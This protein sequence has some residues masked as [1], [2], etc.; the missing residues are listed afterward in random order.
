MRSLML[1]LLVA[2]LPLRM[3]AADGMAVTMAGQQ[4]AS[5][6]LSSAGSMPADCPMAADAPA[7]QG[8]ADEP[9]PMGHCGT[10]HLCAATA[11]LT[12]VQASC[13]SA[14]PAGPLQPR[15]SR[16]VDA[17]LALEL[18]PPIS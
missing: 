17:D 5:A 4:L 13:V 8:A 7:L 12:A 3:W 14:E 15:S 2:L 6:G 18:R 9:A 10:C 1:I 11:G 16:Y